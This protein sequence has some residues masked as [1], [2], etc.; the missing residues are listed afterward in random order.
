MHALEILLCSVPLNSE[1]S[2]SASARDAGRNAQIFYPV[3]TDSGAQI[4]RRLGSN[5]VL[6]LSTIGT[7]QSELTER[8]QAAL[9]HRR[10]HRRLRRV[11]R[12]V[13][14]ISRAPLASLGAL[15]STSAQCS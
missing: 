10:I 1:D 5:E 11:L 14:S 13:Q 15:A 12:D 9:P 2:P 4:E 8:Q 6:H 7:F 3:G